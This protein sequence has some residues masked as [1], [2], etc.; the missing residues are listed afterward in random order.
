MPRLEL[1]HYTRSAAAVVGILTNG[2]AWVPNRRDLIS[3]LVPFHPFD[4]REPQQFGMISFTELEPNIAA[5]HRK[6]FGDFGISVSNIWAER[7]K[8]QKVIYVGRKGP[9]FDALSWLFR[10]GYEQ[11]KASIEFPDDAALAMGYTNK[12]MAFVNGAPLWANLLQ[13]YEYLEPIEH[14]CHQEWRIVHPHPY[15]SLAES[16]SDVIKTVS[17]PLGWSQHLNV[18]RVEPDDCVRL[19]CPASGRDE[20]SAGLPHGYREAPLQCLEG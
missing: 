8:A 9:V 10:A 11:V 1:T 14:S 6:D 12:E 19:I 2:F 4:D 3:H 15:Y 18:L 13:I 7:H 5:A 20:L 17:P 16:K